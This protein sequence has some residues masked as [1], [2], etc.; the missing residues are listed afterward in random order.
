M[1]LLKSDMKYLLSAALFLF[2]LQGCLEN[3]F[4]QKVKPVPAQGNPLPGNT[5]NSEK[6]GWKIE[7]PKGKEWKIISREEQ[8]RLDKKGREV[9]EES[10][11]TEIPKSK[12]EDLISFRKDQFNTFISNIEPF[13]ESVDGN[14]DQMLAV[15][16]QVIK[17][18]YA[19]KNI[20][21][22]YEIAATR[23]DGIMVDRFDIKL[24]SS[25]R[26]VI[27]YQH[28]FTCIIKDHFLNITISANNKEDEETLEKIVF[29][30]VFY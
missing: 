19:S 7:L 29:S 14:Y 21:A 23:I 13:D 24:Y 20:P 15:L 2:I 8:A 16:H 6:I 28:I 12:A 9:I 27:L 10:V 3:P 4:K 1:N 11:G 25:N 17:N 18:S 5:F 30:S 26:K 22:D